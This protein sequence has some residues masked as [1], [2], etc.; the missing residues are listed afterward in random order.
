M[1]PEPPGYH[2]YTIFVVYP[3]GNSWN[4][5]GLSNSDFIKKSWKTWKFM[6]IMISRDFRNF[7][8]VAKKYISFTL[9]DRLE[10]NKRHSGSRTMLPAMPLNVFRRLLVLKQLKLVGIVNKDF[11]RKSRKS[12]KSKKSRKS[13]KLDKPDGFQMFPHG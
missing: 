13:P 7:S 8:K 10:A 2:F 6:K 11:V 12:P 3:C 4:R 5:S 1:L 9:F